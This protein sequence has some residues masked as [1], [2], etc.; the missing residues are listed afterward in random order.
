LHTA[1]TLAENKD[2]FFYFLF[3]FIFSLSL[4][5]RRRERLKWSEMK[6]ISGKFKPFINGVDTLP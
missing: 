3:H 1:E 5:K 2:V 6:M 4:N